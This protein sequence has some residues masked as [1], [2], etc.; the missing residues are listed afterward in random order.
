[1]NRR[2]LY[3]RSAFTPKKIRELKQ[4]GLI[5]DGKVE[6]TKITPDGLEQTVLI[7]PP[8]SLEFITIPVV[9]RKNRCSA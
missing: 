5:I 8:N 9:V 1:M 4:E 6:M 3:Q 7:Q 2:Q